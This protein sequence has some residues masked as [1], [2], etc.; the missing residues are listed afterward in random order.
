MNPPK[1]NGNTHRMGLE[2]VGK[3][4]VDSRYHLTI[5]DAF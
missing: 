1:H 4:R 3:G 5:G 2:R